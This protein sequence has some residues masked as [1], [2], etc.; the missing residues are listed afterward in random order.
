[1][2]S[3]MKFVLDVG[4]CSRD[5]ASIK[6]LIETKF[7]ATV[8][9]ADVADDTLDQLRS[10][11]FDLVLI[12]RKLDSDYSDGMEIIKILKADENLHSVP[13][14]LVTN[15]V[16]H[17]DLAVAN[18]ALRGFGKLELGTLETEGKL[19]AVLG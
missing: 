17:Q 18:G 6:R 15:Y 16:E 8:V 10:R 12:N 3:I 4:N 13:V 9:Q 5:H 11:A 1:M 14:M 7:S 2:K 19:R